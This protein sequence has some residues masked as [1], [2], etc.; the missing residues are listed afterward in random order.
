MFE[1]FMNI[2]RAGCCRRPIRHEKSV[3]EFL[4]SCR[5]FQDDVRAFTVFVTHEFALKQL[6]RTANAAQGIL[7]FVR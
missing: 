3:N 5:F 2:D 1:H 6:R 7:D 4:Q